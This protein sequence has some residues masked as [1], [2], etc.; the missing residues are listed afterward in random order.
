VLAQRSID[1]PIRTAIPQPPLI[2]AGR[3]GARGAGAFLLLAFGIP[4]GIWNV[5]T[6]MAGGDPQLIAFNAAAGWFVVLGVTYLGLHGVRD[7]AW[8]SAPALLTLEA[9]LEFAVLPGWRFATGGDQMDTFYVKAMVLTLVGFIAFW[10]GSLLFLRRSKIRFV[11]LTQTTPKRLVI[12]NFAMLIVGILAKVVLWKLGL[13]AYLS[14]QSAKDSALPYVG[15][16]SLASNLLLGSL[17]VSAIERYGR[18]STNPLTSIIFWCSL[19]SSLVTGAISGM[20]GAF[21]IPVLLVVLIYGITQRRLHRAAFLFPFL[22]IVIY[23]FNTAYRNNLNSGDRMQATTLAGLEAVLTKS[24]VD[25]ARSPLDQA[26]SGADRSTARLSM[27]AFVHDIVGLPSPSLLNGDEKLWLAPIY[28]FIPRFLWEDKPI[29]D[30]GVRLSVAL[31][32]PDTTS[33]AITPIGDLF[34]LNG[35]TG[36]AIGMLI[37]GICFQLY[38][39]FAGRRPLTERGLLVYLSV[40]VPLMNFENYVVAEVSA[41]A[42]GLITITVVSLLIYGPSVPLFTPRQTE[43]G[44]R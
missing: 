15:W 39:N 38:M 26:Q 30:K 3:Q 8:C 35:A 18:Q 27:L 17:V 7:L 11:A 21:V 14:D 23:P 34:M 28:P 2:E 29:F 1:R 44:S 43:A 9:L 22:I 33:S 10:T 4:W 20:K 41:I 25:A 12:V 32:R 36:V 13:L 40:L 31:G 37:Y 16:L 5:V 19:L 6:L 24:L 42:Q